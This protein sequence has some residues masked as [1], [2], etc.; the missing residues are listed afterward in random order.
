MKPFFIKVQ[1]TVAR[2][3]FDSFVLGAVVDELSAFVGGKVQD[4]RQPSDNEI[5]LGLY[6]AEAGE[7]MLLISSHPLFSRTHFVTRRPK[8]PP[9][10][11]TFCA[12]LRSR[13]EGSRIAHVRQIGYDRV[14]EIAFDGPK[15]PHL[16]IAELM[17]KHSN[18]VLVDETGRCVSA[19]KWVSR[20]HSS[21]P[22]VP[23]STYSWPPVMNE[24][25]R[26]WT[27]GGP[28]AWI[29]TATELKALP[30]FTSRLLENVPIPAK[31]LPVLTDDGAYPVPLE[32]GFARGSISV[33]LE[34]YF[35][36]A[37]PQLLAQTLRDNL[38]KSL[39]RVLN[40]RDA[41]LNELKQAA[42]LAT[43]AN[44]MQRYGELILAYGPAAEPGISMLDAW[45]Y[46][47]TEVRIRLDPA[48]GFKDNAN[49]YFQKARH[50]K[51]RMGLVHD[52]IARLSK[53]RDS[54][55]DLMIRITNEPRLSNMQ[56][57][58]KYARE[59]KWIGAIVSPSKRGKDERPYEGHRIR[60]LLGPGGLTYLY[61]ENADANDF[62]TMRVAKP[63]D[64]WLHVRGSTSAHV[65]I[66]TRN[67]PEK[68]QKEHLEY[69]AKVAVQNSPSKHAGYVPVD[70]T[71]RRHVWRPRGAP[72][73]TALY[74]NEKTLHVEG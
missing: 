66:A 22:V 63:N 32:G 53:D 43:R 7:A 1:R 59:R 26:A 50:A 8:N 9:E 67:H 34:Q 30:P 61:G 52:Q 37:I 19:M 45:D 72:P 54:V 2:V 6:S 27:G 62:L 4:V 5:Y 70:Y 41:A 31:W 64:I 11:P 25:E 56:E 14:L 15:G 16:L 49:T 68:I 57:M 71:L 74:K 38:L 51:D 39:E 20:A 23:N 58:Q 17:G 33:A 21:R 46:D 28:L 18:V 60:E 42:E 13:I 44:Q 29:E 48:L 65:V 36:T 73:G 12:T 35:D 69:A 47:G 10:P 40:A 24:T 55:R 3:P